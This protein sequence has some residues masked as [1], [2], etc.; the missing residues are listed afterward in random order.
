MGVSGSRVCLDRM[1]T[2][3]WSMTTARLWCF[4]ACWGEPQWHELQGLNV[5]M[6]MVVVVKTWDAAHGGCCCE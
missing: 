5:A 3:R 4:R 1:K 6:M 2:D